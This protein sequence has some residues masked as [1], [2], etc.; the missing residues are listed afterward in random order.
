LVQVYGDRDIWWKGCYSS[1]KRC[2][3]SKEMCW[4]VVRHHDDICVCM[5]VIAIDCAVAGR[6][7]MG[8]Q[9]RTLNMPK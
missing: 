6:A 5:K 1:S 9:A 8:N 7:E 4:I 2:S 3:L